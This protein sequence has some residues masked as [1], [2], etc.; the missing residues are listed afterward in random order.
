MTHIILAS[1][2]RAALS[3]ICLI[4]FG[5]NVANAKSSTMIS[6]NLCADQ[7][8]LE[9]GN[10]D[11]VLGLSSMSRNPALSYHWRLATAVPA[12]RASAEAALRL[13]PELVLVG[14]YDARYTTVVLAK[15]GMKI[16]SMP[17]W[18]TLAETKAGV[19][20]AAAQMGQKLRGEELVS[21]I[22]RSLIQL[23]R[24]RS[25]ISAPRS[26]LIL[27]RRG[28][29]QRQGV[30]A[31]VLRYAGLRDASDDFDL[32]AAGGFVPLEKF[33]QARPD[34]LVVSEAIAL[35]EDQGQALFL[36]PAVTR[37]YPPNKRL[38][39][40]DAL[41]ICAGPATPALIE[42]VRQEIEAKVILK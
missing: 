10:F 32:P 9:F 19:I 28:Y 22:D 4:S 5:Q 7:L 25:R 16:H 1:V 23:E 6:F 17:V 14:Q 13:A 24:L 26:F 11:Q 38:I 2:L 40:P 31:E 3:S 8:A 37:L 39:I 27:Q 34:Y 30:A 36:H 12:I 29:A 33:I 42:A 18:N 41:S 15:A 20:D 21:D 35:A